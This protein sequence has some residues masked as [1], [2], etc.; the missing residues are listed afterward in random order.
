MSSAKQEVRDTNKELTELT[1]EINQLSEERS[2]IANKKRKKNQKFCQ[3]DGILKQIGKTIG[4][5]LKAKAKQEAIL[6]WV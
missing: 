2:A 6:S 3:S 1:K 4:D 5:A